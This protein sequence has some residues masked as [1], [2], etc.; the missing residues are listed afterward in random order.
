M[1]QGH[2]VV[3]DCKQRR[4]AAGRR[5]PPAAGL[6]P[7]LRA[8][9]V[10]LLSLQRRNWRSACSRSSA[11][12]QSCSKKRPRVQTAERCQ[13]GPAKCC[14]SVVGG[15]SGCRGANTLLLGSP[16]PRAGGGAALPLASLPFA[17]M[18]PQPA[19]VPLRPQLCSKPASGSAAVSA[20][21]KRRAQG[22]SSL[23]GGRLRRAIAG[24]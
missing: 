5:R 8:D 20:G 18:L 10:L 21:E 15:A 2:P 9:P 22:R 17:C 12:S 6:S 7:L 13:T 3:G 23:Q 19:F 14:S 16:A 11:S 24:K 1:D 4:R